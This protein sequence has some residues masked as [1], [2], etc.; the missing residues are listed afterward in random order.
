[1]PRKKAAKT[2]P[3]E[4]GRPSSPA[5]WRRWIGRGLAALKPAWVLAVGA[6][7]YL[8]LVFVLEQ[9]ASAH[10]T[11]RIRA[12]DLAVEPP[13]A[14]GLSHTLPPAANVK[15]ACTCTDQ[16]LRQILQ[17]ALGRNP[18]QSDLV[19]DVRAELQHN[20]AL[21]S[22][23]CVQPL[24]PGTL[25][26]VATVRVPEFRLKASG[27][28]LDEDGVLLPVDLGHPTQFSLPEYSCDGDPEGRTADGRLSDP[29][30]P[31]VVQAVRTL[32]DAMPALARD[33]QFHIVSAH[34]ADAGRPAELTLTL[35]NGARLEWGRLNEAGSFADSL[36]ERRAAVQAVQ[37]RYADL[38]KLLVVRLYDADAPV[39]LRQQPGVK[40][41]AP[42]A[43]LTLSA[44]HAR[45]P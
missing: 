38:N 2:P 18:R 6:V 4:A 32:T 7:A 8:G 40:L 29:L 31:L 14:G 34:V 30:Y 16:D 20:P 10:G 42:S 33:P 17:T 39:E 45:R 44:S 35:A 24:F 1:M 9:A 37:A 15:F 21:R 36:A 11:G 19:A 22:L 25:R 12:I 3:K 27:R 26:V 43:R 13:V 5:R 41:T 28:A 23:D